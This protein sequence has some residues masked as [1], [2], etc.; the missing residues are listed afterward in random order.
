MAPVDR[1]VLRLATYELLFDPSAAPVEVVIDEAVE[2]SRR[3]GTKDSSAFVNG[4][5]DKIAKSR[6][7]GPGSPAEGDAA[8]SETSGPST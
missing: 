7:S 1:N 3:F 6:S 4:I 2:L 5:L 8:S